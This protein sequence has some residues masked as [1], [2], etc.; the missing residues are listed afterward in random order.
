MTALGAKIR[1][2]IAAALAFAASKV[3]PPVMRPVFRCYCEM[4]GCFN[5][6][7]AMGRTF[8]VIS[9]GWWVDAEDQRSASIMEDAGCAALAGVR[10][11]L[12]SH[13]GNPSAGGR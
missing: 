11:A 2:Q 5:E 8:G 3:A 4:L 1:L 13:K 10:R 12:E 7:L 9:A 6:E